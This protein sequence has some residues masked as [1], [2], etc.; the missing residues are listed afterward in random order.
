[1]LAFDDLLEAA[2]RVSDLYVGAGDAGEYLGYVEGLRE[3]ALGLAGAGYGDLVL[4]GEL[5]D[6]E[7]GDDVLE[8]PL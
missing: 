8:V 2:D 6:A 3:E 5:V 4:F 7:D 1:M